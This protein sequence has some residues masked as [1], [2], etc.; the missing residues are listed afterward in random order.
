MTAGDIRLFVF[1][2]GYSARA[3]VARM[4][5]RLE[6]VWGTTREREKFDQIGALGV[7]PI[8]FDSRAVEASDLPSPGPFAKGELANA[9][10]R[11]NHVLVA[12]APDAEGD[13]VLRHHRKNLA[14]IKPKAI[15]YLSTV[16][17]YGNH[18]G[19]WVGEESECRPVSDRARWRLA[20]EAEWQSF[21]AET[22]VP[23]A[24]IRLAGIYGPGRGP[25]E[26][27]KRGAARRIVKPEQIFNR[28]QVDDIAA[29]VDAAL[30]QRA[31]GIF[32]G[33]DDEPAPPEDV[34]A[35]AA[36]LL[37]K[38]ELGVQLAHSTYQDGL[39][40]ILNADIDAER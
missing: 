34:I 19:A 25:F 23:V 1:G 14:A 13:P 15:V 6:E 18:N 21:A 12:I 20:A 38:R 7:T 30:S 40:A 33:A 2:F 31:D 16:G 4:R 37:I 10:A 39:R 22:A 5:P 36:E 11:A 32:N 8:F 24:T 28:I 26:K 35:Y 17:V 9:L 27:I 29:I 3:V